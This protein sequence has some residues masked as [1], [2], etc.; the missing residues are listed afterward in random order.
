MD[1]EL[2]VNLNNMMNMILTEIPMGKIP[3]PTTLHKPKIKTNMEI[4]ELKMRMIMIFQGLLKINL[5]LPLIMEIL[6]QIS[7]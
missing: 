1:L 4:M 3:M 7:I 6:M 2:Q 5:A